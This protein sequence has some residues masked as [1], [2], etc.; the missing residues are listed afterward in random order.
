MSIIIISV[1]F[2]DRLMLIKKLNVV[3]FLVEAA[4][5]T[6]YSILSPPTVSLNIS[7]SSLCAYYI[8]HKLDIYNFVCFWGFH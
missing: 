7:F 1:P 4:N 5:Y 3:E 6:Y 8:A 2:V